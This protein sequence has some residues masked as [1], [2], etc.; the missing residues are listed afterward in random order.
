MPRLHLQ[1]PSFHVPCFYIDAIGQHIALKQLKF[2]HLHLMITSVDL[3]M[4]VIK[5]ISNMKQCYV[6]HHLGDV[7]N[8]GILINLR[9]NSYFINNIEFFENTNE[10]Y[11]AK[12]RMR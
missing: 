12:R 10:C 6:R 7:A 4:V 9:T 1:I 2:D 3:I 11:H 5:R 8:V